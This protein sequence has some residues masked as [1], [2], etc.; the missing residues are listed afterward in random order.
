MPPPS[1]CLVRWPFWPYPVTGTC[2][3]MAQWSL[4][5]ASSTPKTLGPSI[6]A[7]STPNINFEYKYGFR[8]DLRAPNLKNFSGGAC[9][10][11]PLCMHAYTRT[12]IGAPPIVST[13]RRLWTWHE[14]H[15]IMLHDLINKHMYFTQLSLW[16]FTTCHRTTSC[17]PQEID[18]HLSMVGGHRVVSCLNS[19]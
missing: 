4:N 2:A 12:I 6:L 14:I 11:T 1:N 19:K 9:P 3:V 15:N 7:A 5:M 16:G 8:S 10:Q 17:E 13:F 18:T